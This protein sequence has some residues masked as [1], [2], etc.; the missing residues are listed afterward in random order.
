MD[1][2]KASVKKTSGGCGIYGARLCTAERQ[3]QREQTEQWR[4]HLGFSI[5]TRLWVSLLKWK[6]HRG[7]YLSWIFK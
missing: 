5:V 6:T 7:A 2:K 4:G 1:S 3:G